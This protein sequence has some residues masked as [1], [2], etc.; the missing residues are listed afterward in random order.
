[1]KTAHAPAHYLRGDVKTYLSS[2]SSSVQ[3][4]SSLVHQITRISQYTSCSLVATYNA[5]ER[6]REK[7]RK[8]RDRVN[9]YGLFEDHCI[10]Q[11]VY[12][13]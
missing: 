3:L 2:V 8:S 6:E 1:M 5:E 9:V 13:H 10:Y 11:V 4:L 12:P 7:E